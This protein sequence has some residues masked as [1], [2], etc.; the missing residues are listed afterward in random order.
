MSG[1]IGSS[2]SSEVSELRLTLDVGIHGFA[3]HRTA[4]RDVVRALEALNGQRTTHVVLLSRLPLCFEP[5]SLLARAEPAAQCLL[6]A[7]AAAVT[8]HGGYVGLVA[9]PVAT[10]DTTTLRN[11]LDAFVE[12]GDLIGLACGTL[13]RS[14]V[15]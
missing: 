1:P 12:A 15:P 10:V 8:V 13:L 6:Q 9:S 3:L 7:G 4:P 2:G 5:G 14:E 11:A